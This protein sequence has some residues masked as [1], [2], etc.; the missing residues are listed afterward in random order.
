MESDSHSPLMV[1]M[2]RPDIDLSVCI[3]TPTGICMPTPYDPEHY[4][5]NKA[6]INAKAV[7]YNR[8]ARQALRT[9]VVEK[10]GGACSVCG[11][12]DMRVLDIDH[13]DGT[14]YKV[15]RLS[16][17]IRQQWFRDILDGSATN[18]QL[19]CANCHRIKSYEANEQDGFKR[20][21]D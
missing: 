20:E 19:L 14:G 5:K 10:L 21:E 1:H 15:N 9:S 2:V 8:R 6:R 18:A 11:N 3:H 17:N 13:I 12:S 4:Q 7:E 16:G